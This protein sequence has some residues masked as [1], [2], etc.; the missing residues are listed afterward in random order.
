MR[1]FFFLQPGWPRPR[2]SH[3]AIGIA[4]ACTA[5]STGC[6]TMNGPG[7]SNIFKETYASDD[8][9]SH[10]SRNIGIALG[11][12]GGAILGNQ[13]A[14]KS[15]SKAATLIGL[16][17]GATL[18]GFIGND[19]DRRRCE[20]SKIA[21]AH[22]LDLAMT[23][24]KRAPAAKPGQPVGKDETVGMSTT[25]TEKLEQFAN[26]S[27]TPTEAGAKA[28]AAIAKQYLSRA[29]DDAS[30]QKKQ[31]VAERNNLI[32]IVLVGH[33]DDIGPSGFNADLSEQRARAVANIFA[34]EGFS[35]DQIF[36]QGA[37]ETLPIADNRDD[38]GRLRNRRVEIVDLSN[39]EAFN[40][41]LAARKPNVAFYRPASAP[42][43]PTLSGTSQPDRTPKHATGKY[44]T[45]NSKSV[46]ET[47]PAGTVASSKLVGPDDKRSTPTTVEDSSLMDFGGSPANGRFLEVDIGKQTRSSVFSLIS[48]AYAG[49]EPPVGTCAM[50][51]PRV[52]HGVKSLST[53]DELKYATNDFQPG[54]Y[55]T[56]WTERVNGHLVAL[57][58]VNVLRN[59]AVPAS[60]PTLLIYRNYKPSAKAK[61]SFKDT[62]E[63]NAYLGDKA[64]LYRV[65][66]QNG[67]I[68]CMDVVIPNANPTAAQGSNLVYAKRGML[69]QTTFAPRIVR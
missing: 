19:M 66:I 1:A 21:K 59:G 26:G 15:G 37:G 16:G 31:A 67:P 33:T 55:R 24:I 14:D 22:N 13:I 42:M 18:G 45:Q 41:F 30:D 32:R 10:N 3:M 54:A 11:A 57:T 47:R 39:A 6:N 43:I 51:R 44:A 58:N 60:R 4:I 69:Y 36:F 63:V 61:A 7:G 23:D 34:A 56:S 48:S 25:I 46:N 8:P 49:N 64:M 35:R 38:G 17:L 65:F 20:L 62:P 52:S 53:G 29:V 40:A 28:F 2:Q 68:T 12:L 9:C 5:F 50:D 27:A